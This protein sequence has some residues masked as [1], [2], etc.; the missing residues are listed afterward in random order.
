MLY[1]FSVIRRRNN[2]SFGLYSSAIH[3]ITMIL[4]I[5]IIISIE[6]LKF[7]SAAMDIFWSFTY[8]AKIIHCTDNTVPTVVA[9]LFYNTV[10]DKTMIV[11]VM[12]IGAWRQI[13]S[14]NSIVNI[15]LVVTN[16][17]S[18]IAH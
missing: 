8:H 16:K 1:R 13:K 2:N 7:A 12:T 5:N 4:I 18:I 14:L 3:F 6:I 15:T 11:I 10:I 9:N 17:I